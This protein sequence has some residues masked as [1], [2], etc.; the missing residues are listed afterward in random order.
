MKGA[1]MP[2]TLPEQL[3]IKQDDDALLP[4]PAHVSL[5]L[6]LPRVFAAW[7]SRGPY[8]NSHVL[9]ATHSPC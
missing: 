1:E 8:I 9:R 3:K 4:P 6:L 2:E 7:S 5:P